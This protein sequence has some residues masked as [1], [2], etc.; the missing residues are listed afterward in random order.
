[1][2]TCLIPN[3]RKNTAWAEPFCADHADVED[4][5]PEYKQRYL[6]AVRNFDVAITPLAVKLE[7]VRKIIERS[8]PEG[9]DPWK[10]LH[11][12]DIATSHESEGDTR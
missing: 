8:R 3:C 5:D 4:R 10:L 11:E 1:M 12:I 9:T 6:A 7:A 2:G